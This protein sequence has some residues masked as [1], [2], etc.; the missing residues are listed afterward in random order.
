MCGI[1][2]EL[3][4]ERPR[5]GRRLHLIEI[6]HAPL[7][8]RDDLLRHHKYIPALEFQLLRRHCLE[9][10]KPQVAAWGNLANSLY[11]HYSYLAVHVISFADTGIIVPGNA[12]VQ[13]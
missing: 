13:F 2:V 5:E 9:Y 6:D 12:Q 1:L 3:L 11:G 8:L 4:R 7:G 10:K